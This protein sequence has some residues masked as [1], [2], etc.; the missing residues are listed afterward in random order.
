MSPPQRG[1]GSSRN[2]DTTFDLL[3]LT[4][5]KGTNPRL[6]RELRGRAPLAEVLAHP[7]EHPDL[8]G[9][10][11]QLSPA[12][13][14]AE[15]ELRRAQQLGLR[16]LGL[17]E[18]DY[19]AWLG[20]IYD[21]PPVL[22]LRGTLAAEEGE[23]SVAIVGSRAATPQGAVLARAL[24]R[25]LAEAGLVVVSGLARGIDSA[26]HRG[27]LDGHGRTVAI[28]GSGLDVVYPPE[29]GPLADAIVAQGGVVVSEFPF[30]SAPL[31]QNFP[32]RNRVIAGW[33]RAVVV[34][35]AASRSGALSTA[36]SALDAGRDVFAVP[37]HP[38]HETASGTNQLIR[39]GAPLVRDAADVLG[40]LGV[41][42]RPKRQELP[43]DAILKALPVGA[44]ASVEELTERSGR[45]V[46]EVLA[47]LTELELAE[48]VRRLPG[49]L[50]ARA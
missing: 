41:E 12:R 49:A 17:D 23:R 25:G 46:E 1:W 13:R 3:T 11:T 7:A 45:S 37:G 16:I 20:Q 35:E 48:R 33:S 29:A 31:P 38:S 32:R 21:P 18:P 39:D 24:A 44:S 19:P 34:V 9:W 50:Y 14:Q 4:L 8:A 30:G 5:V 42:T 47:R 27:A 40:E 28:L 10:L 2:V 15:Q 26:A 22:Y 36:R 6:V 43:E